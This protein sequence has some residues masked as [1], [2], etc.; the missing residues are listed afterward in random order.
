MPGEQF[1]PSVI[2]FG[3]FHLDLRTQE[4]KKH[5]VKLRLPGQ[6][7][8]ILAMLL[9]NPGELVTREQLQQALWPSDT[10]VDFE[11]GVNAAVNRLRDVMGDSADDPHLIETL[12]RR[13]YRFIGSIDVAQD[14][15][16]QTDHHRDR[17]KVAAWIL[18]AAAC[19]LAVGFIYLKFQHVKKLEENFK[20]VPLTAYSGLEI[21][22]TLSPDGSQVAFAWNG[23]PETGSQGFDLYVKAI[24]NESLLRLT[25]QASDILCPAWSPDGAQI[26]FYRG[27]ALGGGIYAVP[28][29]GGLERRLRFS[30]GPPDISGPIS[31]SPDSKWIAYGES[32]PP[33]DGPMLHLLSLETMESKRIS[34][35]EG[36]LSERFPAFSH[37][38]KQLAYLCLLNRPQNESALY[39]LP[40]SG[41][42]PV[43]VTRFEPG[44]DSPVGIAWTANDKTLIVSRPRADGNFELDE[45]APADGS[46]RALP[47][48]R[49]A[50]YPAISANGEKLAYVVWSQHVDIWRKDLLHPEAPAV[51]LLSSTHDQDAPEYSP[52]GK[53]IAFASDRGGI[54]EIWMSD[55]DGTHLV[56]MSDA[57]SSEAGTPRWSPDSQKIAFDSRHSGHP[58]VYVVD[59]SERMPRKVVTNVPDMST[60]NWSHDGKWLYFQSSPT[61]TP[62]QRIFRCLS[63]GGDATAL[64]T[65]FGAYPFESYDGETVYFVTRE[66]V[67]TLGMMPLAKLGLPLEL[68]GMP[69]MASWST[70]TV[71]PGGIFFVPADSKKSIQ[72]YDFNTRKVLKT[73][74]LDRENYNGLSV[75]HDGRWILY[76]QVEL[77]SDIMLVENLR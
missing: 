68:K 3:P 56:L 64:S 34:H 19:V 57:Q 33:G 35:V 54:W 38:G 69:Q 21:C 58:E 25:H 15:N 18:S 7:F 66:S 63:T 61:Q 43:L 28:V 67:A 22:P 71:V 76:T 77:N 12:P 59:I 72:Y 8:Q 75:S 46:R 9:K 74:D 55:V 11:R 26:A 41:G 47:F 1:S 62:D 44:M 42:L 53:Y 70:W 50:T 24:H 20:P 51:K 40:L 5:S 13:G 29:L 17:Q 37:S 39:S 36:C 2:S 31:W 27:S 45:V 23:D 4:L 52:D 49:E 65:E 14:P 60:P 30:H 10:H 73:F 32:V 48:G 16:N 6:S